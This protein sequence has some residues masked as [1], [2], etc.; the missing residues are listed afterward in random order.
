MNGIKDIRIGA[1]LVAL[2]ALMGVL[3]LSSAFLMG[4]TVSR[5]NENYQRINK[6]DTQAAFDA[7][8]AGQAFSEARGS[9]TRYLFRVDLAERQ[10]IAE[11][12]A[13][14]DKAHG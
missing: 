1:K 5:I 14:Q 13:A 2:V 12:M 9:L 7:V 10:K 6:Y 8:Q 11:E 3:L 4:S